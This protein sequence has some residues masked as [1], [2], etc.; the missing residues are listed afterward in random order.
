MLDNTNHKENQPIDVVITWVDG[1]DSA[2]TEKRF[3]YLEI[4]KNPSKHPGAL[5][6]FFASNNEIRYCVLSILKFAPFVRNIFIV[7]DGQNPKLDEEINKH[8]PGRLNSIRIVNHKEIFEGFEEHLPNFNSASINSLIWRIEGLSNN[9][10]YFND[11]VFLI[12]DVSASDWF[13]NNRPVLRGKWRVPPYIKIFKNFLKTKI[14]RDLL[15]KTDYQPRLS[16]YIRQ[17]DAAWLLGFRFRYFFHCHTPH[18]HNRKILEDFF[19]KNQSL[20]KKNISYRFRS[21]NQFLVSS[22][23]NHLEILSEN[24]QFATLNLGYFH[25]YY[26][27]KVLD[28]K[29]KQCENDLNIKSICVQSLEMLGKDEQRKIFEWMDRV[30][31]M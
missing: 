30:L 10:V 19:S 25:P 24:K 22:L 8:F 14:N 13:I 7:T 28:H 12:R 27:R 6:T 3:R 11:D 31:E 1:S 4:E 17:W 5:P 23:A 16:Y 18:P 21:H 26:S 29:L 20:L 15:N 2:L 9:F